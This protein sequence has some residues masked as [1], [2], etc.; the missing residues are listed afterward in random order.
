MILTRFPI[1]HYILTLEGIDAPSRSVIFE[2]DVEDSL[3][4]MARKFWNESINNV[5]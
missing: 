5:R 1:Q 2:H 3:G 4:N